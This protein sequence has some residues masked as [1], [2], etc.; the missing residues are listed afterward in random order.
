[1]VEVDT[2]FGGDNSWGNNSVPLSAPSKLGI[3]VGDAATTTQ[4][5]KT[6]AAGGGA[7][8]SGTTEQTL[9]I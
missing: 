5:A 9:H 3:S 6:F 2:I 8:N 1:M 7:P 4:Q